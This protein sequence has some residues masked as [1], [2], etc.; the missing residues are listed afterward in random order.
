MFGE[1][2]PMGNF[3][4]TNLIHTSRFSAAFAAALLAA[5]ASAQTPPV[6]TATPCPSS[7]PPVVQSFSVENALAP[8]QILAT[9]TPKLPA[10]VTPTTT[11]GTAPLEI[12][13]FAT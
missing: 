4:L 8:N 12:R 1:R 7:T 6:T 3:A 2:K 10:G 13:Q 5:T 11:G 9:M